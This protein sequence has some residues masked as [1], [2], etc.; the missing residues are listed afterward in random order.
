LVG[1]KLDGLRSQ[2]FLRSHDDFPYD[3]HRLIAA[4]YL[5]FNLLYT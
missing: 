1:G 4:P 3:R 5:Y 2:G